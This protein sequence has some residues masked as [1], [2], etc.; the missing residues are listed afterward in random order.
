M[1]FGLVSFE[2]I[3]F[4]IQTELRTKITQIEGENVSE[5][6]DLN[7]GFSR[8]TMVKGAAWSVPVLAT[9]VAAPAFAA[10]TANY[11]VGVSADCNGNYDLDKLIAGINKTIRDLPIVG[12]LGGL[13]APV[14]NAL[15]GAVEGLLNGIGLKKFKDRGFSVQAV[16]GTVPMGTQFTLSSGGL[17]DLT[18]LP[19]ILQ[20]QAN[21]LGLV[22]I[23]GDAAVL[24]LKR[25][26]APGEILHF[27]LQGQAIDISVGGTV[28]FALVGNDNPATAPGAP[29]V[30]SQ[31]F[32]VVETSLG[33]L[34]VVNGLLSVLEDIPGIGFILGRITA[35]I[36]N[37]LNALAVTVQL[38]PGQSNPV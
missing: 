25:D 21:V 18:L 37:A 20:T 6:L 28:N 23:N 4:G 24:E 33:E 9:A 1:T 12:L 38:C 5:K 32:I 16:A 7:K 31:R 10:T 13:L 27:S 15:Q 36:R 35:P 14:I 3:H 2:G 8:R 34:G 22:N 26:L 17:I 19:G 11:D 29:N 30:V